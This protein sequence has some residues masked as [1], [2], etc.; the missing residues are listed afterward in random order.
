MIPNRH[1]QIIKFLQSILM[2]EFD[3]KAV[4]LPGSL[5]TETNDELSDID[6]NIV[7]K[8]G[9]VDSL[10]SRLPQIV[11][12]ID[13]PL[14][15]L[16]TKQT[17]H[18][19]IFVFADLIEL[20]ITIIDE[21]N[22]NPS[23]V[24]ENIKPLVDNDSLIENLISNSRDLPSKARIDTLLRL[25]SLFLWGTLAVR[26]RILRDSIWD[27]RD[28]VDKLRL[29]IIQMIDLREKTLMGYKSIEKRLTSAEL[30]KLSKNCF[31]I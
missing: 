25:E 19:A 3:I 6:F 31:C 23:P 2:A 9:D 7:T 1:S 28:G 8:H 5:A 12:E 17:S 26:K 27:A 4:F 15:S 29:I 18:S 16:R 13:K 20:G 11:S 22:L 21:K 24:Y 14:F 10:F 30:L